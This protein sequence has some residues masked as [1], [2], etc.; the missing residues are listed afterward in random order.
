MI[1]DLVCRL[2]YIP[3]SCHGFRTL[4]SQRLVGLIGYSLLHRRYGRPFDNHIPKYEMQL[5]LYMIEY[6]NIMK[7]L[8]LELDCYQT[9]K[10]KCSENATL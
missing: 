7:G 6:Y 5:S 1:Q 10:I 9:I 8:W 4:C 2:M 3:L